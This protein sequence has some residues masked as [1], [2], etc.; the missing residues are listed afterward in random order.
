M[1]KR[2]YQQTAIKWALV[3]GLIIGSPVFLYFAYSNDIG[4]ITITNKNW[5]DFCNATS[6]DNPADAPCETYIDFC[7][8]EDTF[9][10][11][12][13]YDPYGRSTPY[14]FDPNV[15][16]WKIYRSWGKGWR[17]IPLTIPCT[18][19][20]C[21]G[22]RNIPALYSVA[23]R[24][25]KCYSTKILAI[26]NNPDDDIFWSFG[27]FDPYWY[28]YNVT[29]LCQWKTETRQ[30]YGYVTYEYTCNAPYIPKWNQAIETAGCFEEVWHSSNSSWTQEKLFE[31]HYDY[32]Y[33]ANKT[34]YWVLRE[35]I[36]T[37]NVTVCAYLDGFQISNKII[38]SS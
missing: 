2:I 1:A 4:S 19:T 9:W 27:D 38:K 33:P 37:E 17:E 13:D 11:P 16:D 18:G 8:N 32:G 36:G 15:K 21:G 34:M 24:K 20:W 7:V 12:V 25:D 14:G 31:H 29:K 28:G 23:W 10:Y 6:W 5:T 30:V 22:K 35:L 3:I 26:K